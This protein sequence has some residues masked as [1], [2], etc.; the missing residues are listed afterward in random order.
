MT[1]ATQLQA[2]LAPAVAGGAFYGENTLEGGEATVYPY[3]TYLRVS[4]PTNNTLGGP[5]DLQNTRVQV[6]LY[7]DTAAGLDAAQPAVLAAMAGAPFTSLQLTSQDAF[8]SAIRVYRR[9]FDFSV[10]STN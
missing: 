3:V 9:S 2:V 1:L 4:S 10:W 5:T 8:E 7:S 6:D